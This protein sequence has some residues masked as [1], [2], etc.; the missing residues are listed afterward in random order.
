MAVTEYTS[1]AHRE[2]GWWIVQND[3]HPGAISQVR[4][5]DHAAEVQRE[6]IAF[7]AGVAR[8]DVE[9]SV[10]AELE[11]TLARSLDEATALR[12]EAREKEAR[13]LALRRSIALALAADG[14]GIRDIGVVLGLSYQRVHQLLHE[15][16]PDAR[17]S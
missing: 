4:R 14:M 6:A 15:Q 16:G 3:Q 10:R 9:V 11:P 12:A 8:D 13:A 5:L 2:A 7:V 1:H 17:A